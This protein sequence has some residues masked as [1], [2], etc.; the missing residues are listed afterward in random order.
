MI[1]KVAKENCTGCKACGD[2]CPTSAISFPVDQEGFWYPLVESRRCVGCDLCECVCPALNVPQG[3]KAPRPVPKVYKAYHSDSIV[4]YRSTSGGLYYGLARSFVEAGNYIVGCVYNK[5]FTGARQVAYNTQ[6]GL[7][8]IMGSKYFQSDTA[9]IYKTV[10]KLLQQGKSVLFCGTGCQIGGLYGFLGGDSP[11]LYTVELI[12]RGINSPMAFSAFL[13]ELRG[14]FHAEVQEVN[15]KNK[16]HGWINLGTL[17]TFQNGKQYY[18]GRINDP[19]VN[20]FVIGNLSLRPCCERCQFK[21]FPRVSDITIGD[22]WGIKFND[23]ERKYGVS[24]ALVNT[25]K[26]DK[27][28]NSAKETMVVEERSLQE[29][30][31][32]NPAL[33]HS[34]KRNPKASVFFERIS[35]GEPYSK[36]VW[37]LLDSTPFTRAKA[38]VIWQLKGV[39]RFFRQRWKQRYHR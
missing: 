12:C 17:V 39:R 38:M 2:V 33:E 5:G 22:F 34:V 32:G 20:A 8:V 18:R 19:W 21:S 15:F 6:N 14:K 30:L 31:K 16:L 10:G 11:N 35:N 1:D 28:L 29:A 37:E 3:P 24:V 4:R 25:E 26:G 27:L 23:E 13:E 7:E 36:V 9:G